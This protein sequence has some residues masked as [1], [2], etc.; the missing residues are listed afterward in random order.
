MLHRLPRIASRRF[1]SYAPRILLPIFILIL[2]P[3]CADTSSVN[4]IV[5]RNAEPL[6]VT[7]A[8][9]LWPDG[10]IP[11]CFHPYA[12]S[13]LGSTEYEAQTARIKQLVENNY[14]SV[15]GADVD[16]TGWDTCSSSAL[17]SLPGTLRVAVNPDGGKNDE[18]CRWAFRHCPEDSSYPLDGCYGARGYSA[19]VE[20]VILVNGAC[21][22]GFGHKDWDTVVLHEFGHALGFPHETLRSDDD[23]CDPGAKDQSGIYLTSYDS[24]SILNGSYCH[25]NPALTTLDRLGLEIAYPKN[26]IRDLRPQ[27]GFIVDGTAFL[28]RADDT[29][30]TSWTW[31]GA[32]PSALDNVVYWDAQPSGT[33][34][35]G[36]SLKA[37]EIG[38]QSSEI[39]GGSFDDF[40]EDTHLL[41]Q[42]E[43]RVD[44]GLHT[45]IL[46]SQI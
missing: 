21:Y 31:H 19:S 32:H 45:A 30:V 24:H 35:T 10:K 9:V 46:Y 16:F 37:S 20:P 25:W 41:K 3:K 6:W 38:E 14:E 36:I 39:I 28:S 22:N 43:I 8:D 44:S 2:A 18:N 15:S 13:D 1:Q 12:P 4:S 7:D 33:T 23:G 26:H 17:G 11:T 34:F 42:T 40:N 27:Y 29:I 5:S